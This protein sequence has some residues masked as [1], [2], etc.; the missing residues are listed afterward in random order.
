L[1]RLGEQKPPGPQSA[2]TR[3][4]LAVAQALGPESPLDGR[5]AHG[6]LPAQSESLVHS[7]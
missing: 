4:L 7:S 2:S 6:T 3:Q 1:T 5:Q